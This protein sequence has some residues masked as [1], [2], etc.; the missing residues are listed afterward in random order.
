M[1][2][3]AGIDDLLSIKWITEHTI[4]MIYPHYYPPGAVQ[5]FLDHHSTDNIRK[6]IEDGNVYYYMMPNGSITGTVT[7]NGDEINRLFVLPDHQGI[8][9]GS[10]LLDFAEKIIS[11]YYPVI[12]LSASFPAKQIYLR[13][14]YTSA[15]FHVID[16][17]DG[18][19]LCYDYMEKPAVK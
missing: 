19:K 16:A 17:P 9:Y 2:M 5:F 18:D 13:K 15:S 3:R 7:I 4:K 8:G 12:K 14:G 11:E 1:I 10:A 6:D